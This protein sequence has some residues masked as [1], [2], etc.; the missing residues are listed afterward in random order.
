VEYSFDE[1][2][3]IEKLDAELT[4]MLMAADKKR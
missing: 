3:T 4:Q 2:P 1:A